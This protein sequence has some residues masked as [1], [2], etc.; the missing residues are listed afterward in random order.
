MDI[1]NRIEQ[2]LDGRQAEIKEFLHDADKVDFNRETFDDIADSYEDDYEFQLGFDIGKLFLLRDLINFVEES[3][4]DLE[5]EQVFAK[6]Q[7]NAEV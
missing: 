5:Q 4:K 1:I 2:Y 6:P 3:K 7:D